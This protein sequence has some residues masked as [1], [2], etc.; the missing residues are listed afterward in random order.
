ME[1][2][3]ALI[4]PFVPAQY[5]AILVVIVPSLVT[6]C[7]V[8]DATIPQPTAGSKW[9]GIRK[10]IS[11]IALSVGHAANAVPAGLPTSV[12]AFTKDAAAVVAAAPAIA[13]VGAQATRLANDIDPGIKL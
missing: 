12:A 7:S 1:N 13:A 3:I 4:T 10:V 11:T 2:L 5:L 8:I 9:V 6:V